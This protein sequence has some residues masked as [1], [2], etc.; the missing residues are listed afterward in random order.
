MCIKS[1]TDKD[2]PILKIPYT[3]IAEP[4][5]ANVLKEREL[6]ITAK[7]KTDIEDPSRYMPK[8]DSD[9]PSLTKVRSD[10]DEP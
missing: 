5:R 6:P 3:E 2:E 8:T 9:D 4:R 10:I 7:S 1:R